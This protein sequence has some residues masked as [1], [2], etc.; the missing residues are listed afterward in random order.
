MCC[1]FENNT[2]PQQPLRSVE[3]HV[4]NA[5]GLPRRRLKSTSTTEIELDALRADA[6]PSD[7]MTAKRAGKAK[8]TGV[9][10]R[11]RYEESALWIRLLRTW[12]GLGAGVC[13]AIV[14]AMNINWHLSVYARTVMFKD[15]NSTYVVGA[16]AVDP[17]LR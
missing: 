13:V 15:D 11:P 7:I 9:V 2:T 17:S 10:A 4:T 5:N 14:L 1:I 6:F 3:C 8:A 16:R 12:H